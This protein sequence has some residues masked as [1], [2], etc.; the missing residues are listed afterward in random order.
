[1]HVGT[2][3]TNSTGCRRRMVPLPSEKWS[4]NITRIWLIY[5]D[6]HVRAIAQAV[7]RRLP[8]AAARFRAQVRSCVGFVLDKIALGQVFSEYFGFPCQLSFHRLFH[9]HHLSCRDGTISQLVADVPSELSHPT[10]TN[11]KSSFLS[12]LLYYNLIWRYT[13][14]DTDSVVK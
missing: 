7:S 10:P 1:M 9:A 4:R 5:I 14:L 13:V 3:K 11:L 12:E 2:L 6:L 8:T